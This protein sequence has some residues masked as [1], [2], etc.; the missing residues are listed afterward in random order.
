MRLSANAELLVVGSHGNR[1]AEIV[2]GTVSSYCARR[3]HCPVVVLPKPVWNVDKEEAGH[4]H[5]R[6]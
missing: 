2:L 3:A 6:G 1:L 4:D 5:A